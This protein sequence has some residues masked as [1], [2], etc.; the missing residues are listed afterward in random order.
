MSAMGVEQVLKAMED[1]N[2]AVE[3]VTSSM[4]GVS[5][6]AKQA[7]DASKTG[8]AIAENVEKGMGDIAKSAGTV[9]DIVHD[10]EIQMASISKIVTLISDL[11]NQTNLLALNAAIEAARAGEAG[12]GFAVV[13]TEVKSLAQ[14]SRASAEKIEDMISTLNKSTKEAAL[15]MDDAKNQVVKGTQMSAEAL[16][17]FRKIKV[18]AEGVANAAA[19]VAAASQEQAATVQEITASVHEVSTKIESTA[20]EASN[21]AAAAQEATA[22]VSEVNR[23]VENVNKIADTVSREMAKFTI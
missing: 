11:A 6:Q 4:E 7:S 13:A 23:V 12:R 3:Q 10:I 21:A 20:K 22:S 16:E 18:A 15:A 1:M 14:E 2:A 19:E 9:Y 17:A 8:A 5:N